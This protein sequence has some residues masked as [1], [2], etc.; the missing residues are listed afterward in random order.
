MNKQLARGLLAGTLAVSC[1]V[2]AGASRAADTV[3]LEPAPFLFPRQLGPLHYEGDHK[4]EQPGLGV[5][6]S[7]RAE[8]MALDLYV[9]DYGRKDIGDGAEAPAVCQEFE[10]VKS[11]LSTLPD[12]QNSKLA[13]EQLALLSPPAEDLLVREAV[14]ELDYKSRHRV[15]YLWLTGGAGQFIKLR[16]S[17]DAALRDELVE[18]RRAILDALGEALRPYSKAQAAAPEAKTPE[19]GKNITMFAGGG[20]DDMTF[21]IVYLGALSAALEHPAV[22][23]ACN[24]PF[25]PAFTEELGAIQ[26][27]MAINASAPTKF[28]KKLAQMEKEGF[29]DDYV[30]FGRHQD[31]WGTAS[32]AG[33]DY[34]SFE[35]WAKKNLKRFEFPQFGFVEVSQ[36]KR[37]PVESA[38]AP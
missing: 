19:P 30:W 9:Y 17:A 15:S 5:G 11:M 6:Y 4:F 8:G 3:K 20:M 36:A 34:E 23:P 27:A 12:Y 28:T 26:A 21:G 24:G 10:G 33:V 31:V 7:Y 35:R 32:P 1:G 38:P 2:G 22:A 14:F 25:I 37:L 29:L 13:T 16:F 18:A